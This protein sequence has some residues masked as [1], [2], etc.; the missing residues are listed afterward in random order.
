MGYGLFNT[1]SSLRGQAQLLT[2][3]L[4]PS[5]T[6][7]F[8]EPLRKIVNF[9]ENTEVKQQFKFDLCSNITTSLFRLSR[10]LSCAIF[11]TLSNVKC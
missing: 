3:V 7:Q 5:V 8:T 2:A 4:A 9:N 6:Q 10:L 1:G 11:K